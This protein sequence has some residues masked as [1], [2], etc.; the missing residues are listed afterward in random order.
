MPKL[1]FENLDSSLL[2]DRYL[3]TI[4]EQGSTKPLFLSAIA[5]ERLMS[6]SG[7]TL[8]F[9]PEYSGTSL[10]LTNIY[11]NPLDILSTYCKGESSLK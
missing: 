8:G 7:N 4:H 2:L 10:P 11:Q 1:C 6:T 3:L 5:S 9:I